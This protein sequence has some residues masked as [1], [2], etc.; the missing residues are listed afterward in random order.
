MA[1]KKTWVEKLHDSK[2][3][4]KIVKLNDTAKKHWKG[5]TMVVPAPLEVDAIMASVPKGKVI[6]I[7]GI[8]Q[9]LADKHKCD[10]GCPLTC[11]IFSWIAAG[12]AGEEMTEGKKNVTPFWRTLKSN[13]ELNPKYPGGVE[14]QSDQLKEEGF[15]IDSSTKVPRVKEFEKYL[16]K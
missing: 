1:K 3:L 13:G 5:E 4:P 14:F 12:A 6:T 16:V 15:E 10:I 8:R 9:K 11:G 2:D 7:D